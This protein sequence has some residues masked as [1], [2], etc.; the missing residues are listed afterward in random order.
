MRPSF[1]FVSGSHS[2]QRVDPILVLI[3]PCG[4][5]MQS[6][7]HGVVGAFIVPGKHLDSQ[8][9]SGVERKEFHRKPE[10]STWSFGVVSM[11]QTPTGIFR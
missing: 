2:M 4:H 9:D 3:V 8:K 10:A 5:F 1:D 6:Q 7:Q 11:S